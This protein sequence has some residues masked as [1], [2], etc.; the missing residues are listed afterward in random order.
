MARSQIEDSRHP[1]S[2]P[3]LRYVQVTSIHASIATVTAATTATPIVITTSAAHGFT[4]GDLVRVSDVVGGINANGEFTVTVV[5]S[6]HFSLDGTVGSGSY[7]SG[8]K[9]Q[10]AQPVRVKCLKWDKTINPPDYSTF[11]GEFPIGNVDDAQKLTVADRIVV[12]RRE[13]S[14]RWEKFSV[15]DVARFQMAVITDVVDPGTPLPADRYPAALITGGSGASVGGF[16]IV[17]AILLKSDETIGHGTTTLV[18][19]TVVSGVWED[20]KI[21][22]Y[23][24]RKDGVPIPGDVVQ[25][26]RV[27]G[28]RIFPGEV[29]FTIGPVTPVTDFDHIYCHELDATD[30]LRGLNDIEPEDGKVLVQDAD[31]GEIGW[32]DFEGFATTIIEIGGG[33]GGGTTYSAGYGM[34]LAST[35][36]HNNPTGWNGFDQNSPWQIFVHPKIVGTPVRTDPLWTTPSNFA[37]NTNLYLGIDATTGQWAFFPQYGVVKFGRVTGAIGAAGNELIANW[38]SGT[39]KFQDPTTG[40]LAPVATNV[41]NPII[42]QGFVV[43]A[44]V[45]VVGTTVINGTCAAVNWSHP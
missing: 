35:T 37:A 12:L 30:Y 17:K 23:D 2:P 29:G 28:K 27:T 20:S 36:F 38:G 15:P 41:K 45:M 31:T 18:P 5:D 25:V 6:T 3:A 42:G 10:L 22:A 32:V 43:D 21:W 39:V 34:Q 14:R 8:G 7:S 19:D 4:T 33:G 9:A 16:P 11:G 24:V 40:I 1:G 26:F 13:D 44:Q